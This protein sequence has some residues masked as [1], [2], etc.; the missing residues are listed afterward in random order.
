VKKEVKKVDPEA[1][2]AAAKEAMDELDKLLAGLEEDN[3]KAPPVKQSAE[4]DELDKLLAG[5]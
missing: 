1:A 4:M 2:K 5:L 3:T